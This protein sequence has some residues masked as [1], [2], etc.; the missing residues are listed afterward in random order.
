[1]FVLT[2]KRC[3]VVL[4]SLALIVALVAA[5]S[6]AEK[7]HK[8]AGKMTMNYPEQEKIEVGDTEGHVLSFG[9]AD[10]TNE[11]TSE[12]TFMD[13]AQVVNMAFGDLVQGSGLHQ[14]YVKLTLRDDAV[15]C[16]WEGAVTTT[17]PE[18]GAAIMSFKGTYSYIKGTGQFEN[19]QGR[20]TYQGAFASDTQY[21]AEW[22]GEYSIAE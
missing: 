19:I 12:H 2:N 11:C 5:T 20:G 22:E 1:M 16:K 8:V 13:G 21:V 3:M 18:E 9:T 10:G 14:G 6:L 4:A 17:V 15:F 7:K